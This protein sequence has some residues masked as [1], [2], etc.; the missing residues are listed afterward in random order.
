MGLH[1]KNATKYSKTVSNAAHLPAMRPCALNARKVITLIKLIN[2]IDAQIFCITVNSAVKMEVLA[3]NAPINI[4][5]IVLNVS[6][7]R[8]AQTA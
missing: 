1:A 8:M 3:L 5:L 2:A 6:Y 7:V 4:M